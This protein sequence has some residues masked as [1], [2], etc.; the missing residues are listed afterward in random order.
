MGWGVS[1]SSVVKERVFIAWLCGQRGG[2][3][4]EHA[5]GG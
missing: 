3:A 1:H 5:C 2:K 4:L